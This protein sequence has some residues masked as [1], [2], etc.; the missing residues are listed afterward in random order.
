MNWIV[1]EKE[2]SKHIYLLEWQNK[3]EYYI[4]ILCFMI[5]MKIEKRQLREANYRI[6]WC[7]WHDP[8]RQNEFLRKWLQKLEDSW[9]NS[10]LLTKPYTRDNSLGYL[11]WTLHIFTPLEFTIGKY[12]TFFLQCNFHFRIL[13][14]LYRY[15]S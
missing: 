13:F 8:L 5:C 12:L 14:A 9:R 2:T 7:R 11:K 10:Y 4:Y 1:K 3:T 6:T 15:T